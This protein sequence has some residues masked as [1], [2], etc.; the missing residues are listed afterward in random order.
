MYY[1][2]KCT[3][4]FP[5]PAAAVVSAY[6]TVERSQNTHSSNAFIVS[7]FDDQGLEECLS[8]CDSPTC[9][10][11]L[12]LCHQDGVDVTPH[13]VSGQTF[14]VRTHANYYEYRCGSSFYQDEWIVFVRATLALHTS[15]A[16]P[17]PC[18]PSPSSQPIFTRKK[19]DLSAKTTCTDPNPSFTTTYNAGCAHT[20]VDADYCDDECYT[21]LKAYVE[22]LPGA[23]CDVP[24]DLQADY[25]Y[26]S[27]VCSRTLIK[28][29]GDS[30]VHLDGKP[31]RGYVLVAN[32]NHETEE[33]ECEGP[34]CEG[35][36]S[37]MYVENAEYWM[38][39]LADV[40]CTQL[41]FNRGMPYMELKLGY[42]P[43][44][45]SITRYICSGTETHIDDCIPSCT[46]WN[47]FQYAGDEFFELFS[48]SCYR[49]DGPLECRDIENP[50]PVFFEQTPG[51]LDSKD[52]ITDE[53][54]LSRDYSYPLIN[55]EPSVGDFPFGENFGAEPCLVGEHADQVCSSWRLHV[56]FAWAVSRLAMWR[57]ARGYDGVSRPSH[58]PH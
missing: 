7:V 36:Y 28:L 55:V 46:F 26:Y 29:A 27:D 41:G 8:A 58:R 4:D 5:I 10:S 11:D 3:F 39:P 17:S 21:D 25:E 12:G 33:Q 52:I 19:G 47:P 23:G 24:A 6:L 9:S 1:L 40:I 13:I 37:A 43:V 16:S 48:V 38:Q 14:H 56:V 42:E 31:S 35:A 34:H 15:N 50:T 44:C 30:F 51:D 20:L 32:H 49:V 53:V 45:S 18:P 57:C 2:C 54:H 22:A